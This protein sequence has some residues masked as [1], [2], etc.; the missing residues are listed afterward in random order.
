MEQARKKSKENPLA[1][2]GSTTHLPRFLVTPEALCRERVMLEPAEAQHAHVR[3]L[4]PASKVIAF[5]GRGRSRLARV[6]H[7]FRHN[8][9]LELLE[10][11]PDGEGE[12]PLELTLAVGLL[13]GNKL[14]EVIERTTELGVD[15][16]RPFTSRYSLARLSPARCARW[17]KIAASAAKL[18]GRTKIPHI[19]APCDLPAVLREG[20]T[21]RLM[22]WEG[23]HA[24]GGR[25]LTDVKPAPS[26]V[27]LLVGPEG[28][29]A[30]DEVDASRS[31]GFCLIGLGPRILRAETAAVVG[32]ALCQQLW[33]D[34][35]KRAPTAHSAGRCR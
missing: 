21:C 32:V 31:A 15:R 35:G 5:D 25:D 29:F 1:E 10:H 20:G 7:V 9:E 17:Q 30:P 19:D 27:T 2:Q 33:G 13:K 18:S 6:A 23:A 24:R 16:I 3:R 8:V 26:A 14:D 12:S 34:L 11:L 22:F 28:G 4:P